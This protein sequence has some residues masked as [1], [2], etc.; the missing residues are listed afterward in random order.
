[1]DLYYIQQNS[2]GI[3][4]MPQNLGPSINTSYDERDPYLSLDG[5]TLY[6][7]SNST[8]SYGGYDIF[9]SVYDDDLR[10]WGPA[11]NVQQPINSGANDRHFRI[12]TNGL[13]AYYSSNR[14][15]GY[16]AEDLYIAYFNNPLRES[17]FIS[18]PITFA[19]LEPIP[20]IANAK[21]SMS[22]EPLQLQEVALEPFFFAN[23]QP[24]YDQNKS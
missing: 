10:Q 8:D 21:P 20:R 14:M 17:Q 11:V 22:V 6:F 3:W 24:I 5:R 15:H 13:K 23:G 9:K 18:Y 16:G 4:S 2:D 7:S 1:M 19:K 12:S